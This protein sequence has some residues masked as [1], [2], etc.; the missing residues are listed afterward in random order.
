ME[1]TFAIAESRCS[2]AE[3]ENTLHA[4]NQAVQD[5]KLRLEKAHHS[6][7]SLDRCG[8]CGKRWHQADF[9]IRLCLNRECLFM[10]A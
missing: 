5:A 7:A 3:V 10:P 8:R 6:L 1:D 2:S 4:G 9:A